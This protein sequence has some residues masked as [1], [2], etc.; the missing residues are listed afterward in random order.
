M[1]LCRKKKINKKEAA[2]GQA[3][4]VDKKADCQ[5]E[6]KKSKKTRKQ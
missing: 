6:N 4:H 3:S 1:K 5:D 2:V